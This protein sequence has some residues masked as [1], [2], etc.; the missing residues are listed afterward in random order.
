MLED[1]CHG[2]WDTRI[3]SDV[4][5]SDGYE[6][7]NLI[8]R[9]KREKQKGFLA[10]GFVKPVVT[11]LLSFPFPIDVYAVNMNL[12]VGAQTTCGLEI[13]AASLKSRSQRDSDPAVIIS[14][15]N[16]TQDSRC[17]VTPGPAI[18]RTSTHCQD[19]SGLHH[20]QYDLNINNIKQEFK[21]LFVQILR[22]RIPEGKIGHFV[23]PCFQSTPQ[24]HCDSKIVG[25][26]C[27]NVH[28]CMLRHGH[29]LRR[30]S[31]LVV[32]ITQ[33]HKGSV[34]CLGGIEVFGQLA[35]NS[36]TFVMNYA[37]LISSRLKEEK[38]EIPNGLCTRPVEKNKRPCVGSKEGSPPATLGS[39]GLPNGTSSHGDNVPEDFIDPITLSIMTLPVLL[40]C[41]T[42]IDQ[43]TLERHINSEKS[44]G[45][46]PSD[47]FT[48]LPLGSKVIPNAALK[49]RIDNF[50]LSSDVNVSNLG[51]TIG[52]QFN[53]RSTTTV[54]V[55]AMRE[56]RKWQKN[57][58]LLQKLSRKNKRTV[59]E[60]DDGQAPS[61]RQKSG[62]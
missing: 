8:S 38:K 57:D 51:R 23:N 22:I 27:T 61:K 47:P 2:L 3:N 26:A 37:R 62:L 12:Q 18:S 19:I 1:F 17:S 29:L 39:L 11:I 6:I 34:P 36:G 56:G 46:S 31:H 43:T 60:P 54:K 32:R 25:N 24:V 28:K 13:F 42:T 45:H 53:C 41:G 55:N 48:G 16:M 7:S 52:S 9:D 4:V 49:C 21:N 15:D 33:V 30:T 5:S 40:P 44:W 50:L 20:Y 35:Q 59:D 58:Q 10:A 14:K